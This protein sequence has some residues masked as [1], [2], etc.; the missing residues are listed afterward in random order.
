MNASNDLPS[1]LLTQ[2][3]PWRNAATWRIAFSGGLDSTVLLHLLATLSQHHSL[4][5][6]SLSLIH[7]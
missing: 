4:P 2:L 7:I 3:I 6:L 1:R 5:A